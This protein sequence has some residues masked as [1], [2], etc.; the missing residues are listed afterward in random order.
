MPA[1]TLAGVMRAWRSMANC[2]QG[3]SN[4]VILTIG[5]RKE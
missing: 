3:V 5:A 2:G 1:R 4:P